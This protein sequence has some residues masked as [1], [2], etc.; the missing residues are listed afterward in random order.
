MKT[1]NICSKKHSDFQN[2][3]MWLKIVGY[4]QKPTR[5]SEIPHSLFSIQSTTHVPVYNEIHQIKAKYRFYFSTMVML[6]LLN[7]FLLFAIFNYL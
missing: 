3:L 5:V 7:S 4:N 2:N 1:L 6:I